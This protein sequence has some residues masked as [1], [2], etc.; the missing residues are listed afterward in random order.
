MLTSTHDGNYVISGATDDHFTGIVGKRVG[1]VKKFLGPTFSIPYFSTAW[2][3]RNRVGL[4]HI[5]QAG[6]TLEFIGLI[7]IKGGTDE[8]P[9]AR[10][11][12][13]MIDADPSLRE[14]ISSVT[15]MNL[16]VEES[17]YVTLSLARQHFTETYG[18]INGK[19]LEILDVIATDIHRVADALAPSPPQ[20]IGSPYIAQKLGCSKA[21]ITEMVRDGKIPRACLV[22]GTGNGKPWKFYRREIDRW[23]ER[24]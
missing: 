22:P 1:A 7:G 23:I 24:R 5:L 10:A 4:R 16:D 9:T 8:S 21:W 15:E 12:R 3:N 2:V 6:E 20:K 17:I 19:A 13:A 18:P 11:M 14:I